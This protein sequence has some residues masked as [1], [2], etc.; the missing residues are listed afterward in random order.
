[1]K[2]ARGAQPKTQV[3]EK[4]V[5]EENPADTFFVVKSLYR[6]MSQENLNRKN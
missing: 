1:L 4:E 3:E 2:S 5:E 6:Q